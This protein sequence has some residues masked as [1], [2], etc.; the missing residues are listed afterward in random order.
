[1]VCKDQIWG[2]QPKMKGLSAQKAKNNEFIESRLEK[3]VKMS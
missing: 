2:I 1:M 3:R